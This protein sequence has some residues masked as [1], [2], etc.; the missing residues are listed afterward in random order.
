[1]QGRRRVGAKQSCGNMAGNLSLKR[2]HREEQATTLG[3]AR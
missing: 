2:G 3:V 1:M